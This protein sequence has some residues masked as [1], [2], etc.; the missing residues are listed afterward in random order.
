LENFS[1]AMQEPFPQLTDLGLRSHGSNAVLPDSFLGG[2]APRLRFFWLDGISFPGLPKLLLSATHLVGLKLWNIP[3]SGYISPEAMLTALSMLSSLDY[4]SL[5][6]ASPRSR[7]D[8]G[9]PPPPPIR[10]V[11]PALTSLSFKGVSIY[12]DDLVALIDA[13]RLN[14]LYVTFFNQIVLDTPQLFQFICRTPMLK[15]PKNA[16]VTFGHDVA[17][18]NLSSKTSGFGLLNVGI[19]CKESSGWQV[20]SLE[21][22]FTSCLPPLS[23]L[24]DLYI[25]E[26][27]YSLPSWQ[28]NVENELWLELLHP[29]TSVK[30]LYLSKQFAPQIMTALQELVGF[31]TSEVV[32]TLQNIF[33][34]ELRPPEPVQ[35]GFGQFVAARQAIGHP[36]AVSRWDNSKQDMVLRIQGD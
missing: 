32:P 10:T 20:S 36:I 8:Q 2:A 23:T 31:R 34:E 29:F 3:H 35:E 4:L 22:V 16:R 5:T 21:Q 26:A 11:L 17:R 25:H 33:L 15:A 1:T 13:P 19:S 24:E 27:P 6:F 14:H 9:R 28:D 30:N 12:L 7:P 18:I